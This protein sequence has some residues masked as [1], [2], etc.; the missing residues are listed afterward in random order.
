M[1]STL[2]LLCT[3]FDIPRLIM[4]VGSYYGIISDLLNHRLVKIFN[5]YFASVETENEKLKLSDFLLCNR[6][7]HRIPVSA[8]GFSN[9]R[10][11]D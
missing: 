5:L 11:P 10:D 9:S 4:P 8:D 3:S 7:V 2:P 1:Y 6:P